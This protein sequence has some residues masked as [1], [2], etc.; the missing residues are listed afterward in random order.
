MAHLLAEYSSPLDD[1]AATRVGESIRLQ[2]CCKVL[3]TAALVAG[4]PTF[5]S[6]QNRG[7]PTPVFCDSTLLKLAHG[8]SNGYRQH[9]DRCEGL[10][11]KQV[12]ENGSLRLIAIVRSD[13]AKLT[14]LKKLHISWRAVDSDAVALEA[15]STR[16]YLLY[17]MTT[18]QPGQ[19]GVYDWDINRARAEGLTSREFSIRAWL[20]DLLVPEAKR[21]Y[22][23][24][25]VSASP[26][27]DSE[28]VYTAVV[29]PTAALKEV[30]VSVGELGSNGI[31]TN[32]LYQHRSLG[33]LMYPRDG[34]ISIPLPH[35]QGRLIRVSLAS[36]TTGKVP[37]TLNFVARGP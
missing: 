5:G 26:E 8:S 7:A 31:V 33:R 18:V 24:I 27:K 25:R 15:R 11:S 37:I 34:P 22:V 20:G 23:P 21:I 28:G 2:W 36:E 9:G 19:R 13:T 4:S 3:A 32:W 16:P 10:H 30:Y 17:T 29:I 1:I 35:V 6:A 12:G 14:G